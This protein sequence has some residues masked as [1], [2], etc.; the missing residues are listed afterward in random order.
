LIASFTETPQDD[1]EITLVIHFTRF[2]HAPKSLDAAPVAGKAAWG[3]QMSAEF[4]NKVR[5]IASDVRTDPN[6]LIAATTFET[7]RSFSASQFNKA[8]SGAVGVIQFMPSTAE[9][10]GTT[11]VV[12]AAMTV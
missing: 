5:T 4:C 8:G 2:A 6:F 12:L 10:L 7:G 9:S 11:S 3:V 1:G